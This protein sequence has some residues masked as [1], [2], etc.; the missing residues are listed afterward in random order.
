MAII[1]GHDTD[2]TLNGTPGADIISG[3]VGNDTLNGFGGGDILI[4]GKG[5]DRLDGGQG[6]DADQAGLGDGLDTYTASGTV[7]TDRILAMADAVAIGLLS[8]FGPAS[9]IEEISADGHAGV[10]IQG[11]ATSDTLNFSQTTLTGIVA[12]K[13]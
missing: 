5:S 7:G 11:G 1:T 6:S 9:G 4:G 3:L 2:D 10:T 13:G 12:I 8:V